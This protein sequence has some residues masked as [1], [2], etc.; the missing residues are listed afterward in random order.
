[1]VSWDSTELEQVGTAIE[2]ELATRPADETLSRYTVMWVV[3]VGSSLFVRSAYGPDSAWYRR[4]LRYGR[5]R[6]RAGGVERE[7]VL[8]HL[9]PDDRVHG[10]IDAAFRAK[11]DRYGRQIVATVVGPSAADVTLRLDP[12]PSPPSV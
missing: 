2:L 5:G 6:I 10:E 9:A 4:A 7:V 1:L 3:R 8:D 12:A 11:Y